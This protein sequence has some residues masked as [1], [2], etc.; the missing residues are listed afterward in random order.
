[1][2]GIG[3]LSEANFE[4]IQRIFRSI[5]KGKEPIKVFLFGSRARGDHKKYSDIDLLV[6]GSAN[7]RQLR[8][9][10]DALA[11][12]NLPFKCDVVPAHEIY[13]HYRRQIEMEKK[14][15]FELNKPLQ[16]LQKP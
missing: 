5:L 13:E 8:A 4:E 10:R 2:S 14:L 7:D 1:M 3:G 16:G 9:L 6:D 11:E 15:I 12:S